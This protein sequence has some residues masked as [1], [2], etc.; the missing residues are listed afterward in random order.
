MLPYALAAYILAGGYKT[1]H[2]GAL[3][4]TVV[5]LGVIIS[6]ACL[7]RTSFLSEGTGYALGAFV[8]SLF[9]LPIFQGLEERWGSRQSWRG[10]LLAGGTFIVL[11][12]FTMGMMFHALHLFQE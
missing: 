10:G 5:I 12:A 11:M 7:S 8:A 2:G 1:R 6:G 4:V 3:W 9:L